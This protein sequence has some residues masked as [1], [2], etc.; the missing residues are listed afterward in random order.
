M[1]VSGAG[2]KTV[3]MLQGCSH[4]RSG[5]SLVLSNTCWELPILQQTRAGAGRPPQ[6]PTPRSH[7]SSATWH[8]RGPSWTAYGS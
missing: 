6:S 1:G 7:I 3:R 4:E 8:S 5:S 2:G